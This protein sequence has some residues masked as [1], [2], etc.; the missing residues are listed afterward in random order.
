MSKYD[1]KDF[2]QFPREVIREPLH[3]LLSNGAK[4]L[5]LHLKELEHRYCSGANEEFYCTDEKLAAFAHMH[6]N[7]VKKYKRELKAVAG[8]I[9]SIDNKSVY[10]EKER[11]YSAKKVTFYYF[12]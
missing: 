2:F 5:L 10:K 3:S 11:K 12:Y 8:D 9:I 6:L 1:N 7:T 4:L